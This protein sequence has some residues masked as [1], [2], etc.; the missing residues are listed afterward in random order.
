MVFV[1]HCSQILC[2]ANSSIEA[3]KPPTAHDFTNPEINSLTLRFCFPTYSLG[4]LTKTTTCFVC[5]AHTQQKPCSI[6]SGIVIPFITVLSA[7][8]LS[9]PSSLHTQSQTKPQ[10]SY[11]WYTVRLT[12]TSF[13]YHERVQS[14]RQVLHQIWRR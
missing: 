7:A 6:C 8:A 5:S 13:E 2:L 1:P 10:Y 14:M 4:F 3:R 9:S 11:Q 12:Q